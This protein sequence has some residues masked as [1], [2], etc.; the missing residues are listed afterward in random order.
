MES[1][2]HQ[3]KALFKCSQLSIHYTHGSGSD[4]TTLE[5]TPKTLKENTIDISNKDLEIRH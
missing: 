3:I 4:E 5:D 1:S 2:G